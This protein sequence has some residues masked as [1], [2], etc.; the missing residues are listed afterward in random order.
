MLYIQ[1]E[2]C[3]QGGRSVSTYTEEFHRLNGWIKLN[4]TGQQLVAKYVGGLKE[5]I[6][7]NLEMNTICSLSQAN[8]LAHKVEIRQA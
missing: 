7:K 3:V 5:F 4:E 8:N 6:Q 1:Y 2:C